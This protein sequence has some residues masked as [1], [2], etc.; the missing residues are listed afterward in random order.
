MRAAASD[1]QAPAR[2][3]LEAKIRERNMTLEEF[4][5]YA[6]TFARDNGETGT[7][8]ARHLQRLVGPTPGT[9]RPATRRLLQA[10]FSIPLAELLGPP[11]STERSGAP[12]IEFAEFETNA[13][14]LARHITTASRVDDETIGLLAD[15]IENTRR[16][17][18]RFGA[19]TLL[20]ALRL[21]AEHIDSLFTHATSAPTRR[22]LATVLTDAHTLAG[23]QS[24]D[25]GE[26]SAAWKHYRQACDAAHASES[27]ALLAHALA[28][29]AVVL[30]DVGR[31]AEGADMSRHAR[32]IGQV[33]APL[34]RAWLAAAHGEAL[35]ADGRENAS[36]HA[37]EEAAQRL[38]ATV[39]RDED[40]PYLALD[41]VHLARW[42]GHA[43]ARFGHAD[44]VP[45]LTHALTAHDAE[46][47]RAE[48]GL[49]TDLAIAHLASG[50]RDAAQEQRA[51]AQ[52]IA[53]SVGS[54]RQ[55][56]RLHSIQTGEVA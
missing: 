11:T 9:P 10:I 48:A 13:A 37:F 8:S 54:A 4:A 46:F 42:R 47:S 52:V 22:A 50:E 32:M 55:R 25:R 2:T 15:Q 56:R 38:P 27:P 23:W 35:A 28:E 26:V 40:G 31:T 45:V 17:D 30:A 34:L 19:A 21:H 29:R 53:E 7:L 18:R 12:P 44:A 3:L 36:L 16:L 39:E 43:L 14:A 6:E 24:L 33:G 51:A 5:E 1:R 41:A 20:G 49:R